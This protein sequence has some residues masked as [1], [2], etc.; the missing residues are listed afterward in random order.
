MS[1]RGSDGIVNG[2]ST[3]LLAGEASPP[4]SR[5]RMV[6]AYT[7]VSCIYTVWISTVGGADTGRG[8]VEVMRACRVTLPN[9]LKSKQELPQA[10]RSSLLLGAQ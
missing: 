10:S 5:T 6:T 8:R 2:A 9:E 4:L 1:C 3:K 7:H